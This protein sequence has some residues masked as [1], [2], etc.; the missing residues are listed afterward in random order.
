MSS[1]T[2]SWNWCLHCSLGTGTQGN[3]HH[4][5]RSAAEPEVA[6]SHF[7]IKE[8]KIK[9]HRKHNTVQ[10]TRCASEMVNWSQSAGGKK[11]V[12]FNRWL[13]LLFDYFVMQRW[14]SVEISEHS[15]WL[16]NQGATDNLIYDLQ[17]PQSQLV[18]MHAA[19]REASSTGGWTMVTHR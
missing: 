17:N 1:V 19:E 8:T 15:T 18:H 14:K 2:L 6:S 3:K 4:R 5:C 9:C 12:L 13:A 7:E 16:Q 11:K 10:T